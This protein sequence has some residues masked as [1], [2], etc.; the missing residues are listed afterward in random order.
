M[1]QTETG[2]PLYEYRYI[3]LPGIYRGVMAQDVARHTP[4]AVSR[5]ESGFYLV[6]YDMLGL[7]LQ[8]IE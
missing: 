7:T 3:G 8:R 1:G 6:D 5:H 2:L 4:A